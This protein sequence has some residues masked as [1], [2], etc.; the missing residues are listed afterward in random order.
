M[1]DKITSYKK[2]GYNV[3][4]VI[5]EGRKNFFEKLNERLY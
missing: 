1:N 4:L 3:R 5:G 2:L